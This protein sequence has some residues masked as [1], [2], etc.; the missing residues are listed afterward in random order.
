LT[1]RRIGPILALVMRRSVYHAAKA[2]SRILWVRF[3]VTLILIAVVLAGLVFNWV[4]LRLGLRMMAV[5]Y[6]LGVLA[7]YALFFAGIKLWLGHAQTTLSPEVQ[8]ELVD[9]D[10]DPRATPVEPPDRKRWWERVDI[11][12]P[13]V[14]DGEGCLV[15]VVV[16]IVLMVLFG[17]AA[18]VVAEAPF[19]LGEALVQVTLAAALRSRARRMEPEHWSGAVLRATWVPALIVAGLA[20]LAG[21]LLESHCP[22]AAQMFEALLYCPQ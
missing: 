10:G 9:L 11:D 18:Y 8:A 3:H 22:T 19:F 2:I 15:V 5:R 21:V 14:G 17:V 16:G 20:T 12:V 6:P 1:R 4:A 7:G 13:D